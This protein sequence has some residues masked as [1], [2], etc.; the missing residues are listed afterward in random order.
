MIASAL[1]YFD[2]DAVGEVTPRHL[3]AEAVPRQRDDTPVRPA[4]GAVCGDHMGNMFADHLGLA[5]SGG[6]WQHQARRRLHAADSE[7]A[8]DPADHLGAHLGC[9]RAWHRVGRISRRVSHRVQD[10]PLN[11][12][13]HRSRAGRAQ[14][15]VR[16]LGAIGRERHHD[17]R[18]TG[19]MQLGRSL[20]LGLGA[21][22]A[23]DQQPA[24]GR[25]MWFPQR[26]AA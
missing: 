23:K 20:G 9:G 2:L 17:N 15:V 7:K 12:A 22:V 5:G 21:D 4:I 26:A 13:L 6:A 3:V 16:I 1:Q 14:Q 25:I 24:A 19:A 18:A 8:V 11:A 10:R